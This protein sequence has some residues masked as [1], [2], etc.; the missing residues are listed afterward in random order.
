MTIVAVLVVFGLDQIAAVTGRWSKIAGS[1]G[2][3]Y[4][5]VEIYS[6]VLAPTR[7]SCAFL[8]FFFVQ[9]KVKRCARYSTLDWNC[10]KRQVSIVARRTVE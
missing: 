10:L 7:I 2:T 3:P 8:F 4:R 1:D 6:E 9:E 5:V